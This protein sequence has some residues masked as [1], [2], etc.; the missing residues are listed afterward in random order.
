MPCMIHIHLSF[1]LLVNA[2]ARM[3]VFSS[4]RYKNKKGDPNG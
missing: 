3:V 1:V 4:V 2:K